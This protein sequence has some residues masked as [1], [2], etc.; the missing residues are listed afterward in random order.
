MLLFVI[1]EASALGP[2]REPAAVSAI[3]GV[4]AGFG[5]SC[6]VPSALSRYC[7]TGWPVA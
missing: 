4:C 5:G 2:P 6:F 1:V 3:E 7:V